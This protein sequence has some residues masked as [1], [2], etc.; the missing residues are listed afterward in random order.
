VKEYLEAMKVEL[1]HEGLRQ[2]FVPDANCLGE[3]A[4]SENHGEKLSSR[5]I[6][7]AVGGCG[8]GSP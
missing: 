1:V 2:K 3:C 6:V 5:R 8:R 4:A 7:L